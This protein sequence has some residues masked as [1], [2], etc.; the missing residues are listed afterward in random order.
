[1]KHAINYAKQFLIVVLISLFF[2]APFWGYFAIDYCIVFLFGRLPYSDAISIGIIVLIYAIITATIYFD[3]VER[4]AVKD[5]ESK[6]N[7]RASDLTI[8]E[9]AIQVREQN[10]VNLLSESEQSYPWMASQFADLKYIEDQRISNSL[11]TKAH[12][13]LKAADEVAKIAREKRLLQAANKE[14][15]YQIT[16][17]ETLFPWLEDFKETSPMEGAAYAFQ[18]GSKSSDEYDL[19][20]KWLSPEEYSRLSTADKY[21]L[22]LERYKTR[23]KSDWDIGIEYERYVGY[24]YEKQGYNVRYHGAIMG[25]QDMGRDLLAIKDDK[26]LIIQCKRWSKEKEIHEKH[27]FQLFGSAV[28]YKIEE[29]LDCIPLFVTTTSLSDV[30]RKCASYLKVEV[31]EQFEFKDYPMI[32][33]N[34]SKNGSKIYHLPFDQQY[35]KVKINPS[36]GECYVWTV[37]EAE[38]LGFRRAFRWR[39]NQ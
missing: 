10:Y 14:L 15:E 9:K 35:D 17:Y 8:K 6:Y 28:Q 36:T 1:M 21:Q 5:Y 23:K 29:N 31:A 34:I 39:G 18:T 7:K 38:K 12:P 22:A 19:L 37:A 20:R 30:A 25:M 2:G 13:A 27:I 33:C 11:R 3:D 24:L 4:T 16:Y 32:K 26:T